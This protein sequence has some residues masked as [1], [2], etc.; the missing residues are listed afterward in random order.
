[1]TY[2]STAEA[3]AFQPPPLPELELIDETIAGLVTHQVNG[4]VAAIS[5]ESIEIEGMTAPIGAICEIESP[6]NSASK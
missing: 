4:Q 5:G 1:M 3:F 6:Q 2:G